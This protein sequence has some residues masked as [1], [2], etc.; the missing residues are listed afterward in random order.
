MDTKDQYTKAMGDITKELL[1]EVSKNRRHHNIRTGLF[2]FFFI[3]LFVF[4]AISKKEVLTIP[5]NEPY[6]SLVRIN[7]AI[8]PSSSSSAQFL[9][10]ILTKAFHDKKSVGVMLVINS[11]GGT[12]VQ[13]EILHQLITQLKAHTNKKVVAI[14]EDMLTSGAY[15]LATAADQIYVNNS[16][17]TGSIGVIQQSYGYTG[18]LEK[19][20]IEARTIQSGENKMRLNP[21]RP[22]SEKDLVKVHDVLAKV[23]ENFI[24]IVKKGRGEKLNTDT[25]D[26]FSGDYWTGKQ[27]VE[28]GLVDGIGN[29]NDVMMQEFNVEHAIDYSTKRGILGGLSDMFSKAASDIVTQSIQSMR[30]ELT[31][32]VIQ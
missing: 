25:P 24:D 13:S 20:G 12:P 23:H 32:T 17:L 15:L 4:N 29:T 8:E 1:K 27:A 18:L 11:P 7:G 19:V 2:V 6:I 26:L 3:G 9:E 14:G 16:T 31:K 21:L 10:P 30:T 5:A 22:T 28:Y